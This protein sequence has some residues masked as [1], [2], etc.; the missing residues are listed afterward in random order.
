ME[1]IETVNVIFRS[2]DGKR[3]FNSE[4]AC[5]EYEASVKKEFEKE[6]VSKIYLEQYEI[7]NPD[8]T[9]DVIHEMIGHLIGAYGVVPDIRCVKITQ[10]TNTEEFFE[11]YIDQFLCNTYLNGAGYKNR[12]DWFSIKDG[13]FSSH[14]KYYHEYENFEFEL[15]KSYYMIFSEDTSSDY[16]SHWKQVF[17]AIEKTEFDNYLY[18]LVDRFTK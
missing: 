17:F 7:N 1:R 11:H 9:D 14:S 10:E 2:E 3:S 12:Y 8:D 4:Q 16:I 5:L 6:N 13:E 18:S 15:G